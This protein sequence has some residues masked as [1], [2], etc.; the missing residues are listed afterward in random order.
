MDE[1]EELILKTKEV[2]GS[3]TIK[4]VRGLPVTK[5]NISYLKELL[6]RS[7]SNKIGNYIYILK[8]TQANEYA[9]GILQKRK[10]IIL[11]AEVNMEDT[12]QEEYKEFSPS[13]QNF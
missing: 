12:L 4:K 9:L 6:Q 8:S 1:M 13:G 7:K 11:L 2:I 5:F 10:R 3:R